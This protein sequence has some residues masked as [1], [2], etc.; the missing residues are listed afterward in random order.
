MTETDTI[1]PWGAPPAPPAPPA[2]P[3]PPASSLVWAVI[4]TALLVGWLS[5]SVGWIWGAAVVAAVFVH[6]FGHMLVINWAGSGPSSLRIIPFFGG[7]ATMSRAPD[8]EFKGVLIALSGPVFGLIATLPFFLLAQQTGD[9][10]WL[11]GAFLIAGLNLL[12]LAPAPPLDG[13]KALGPLLARIHPWLEHAALALVGAAAAA[14]AFS[15]GSILIGTVI[16]LSALV[17]LRAKALRP[18]AAP[19]TWGDWA[20]GLGLYI[21][22]VGLCALALL[23]ALPGASLAQPPISLGALNG[24]AA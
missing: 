18:D 1:S 21:A 24:G 3:S 11:G 9:R 8:T 17:S 19:L 2:Q 4:S 7:A 10:R 20:A 23:N 22:A 16:G 5:L 14:W 6:E 12:N 15:H 13:S